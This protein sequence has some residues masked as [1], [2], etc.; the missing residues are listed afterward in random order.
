[1]RLGLIRDELDPNL[2]R[3]VR[4][5]VANEQ[6]RQAQ[7]RVVVV[8]NHSDHPT[9]ILCGRGQIAFGFRKLRQLK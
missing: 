5:A 3:F 8:R 2:S 7:L 1:M 4:L 9:L 6:L